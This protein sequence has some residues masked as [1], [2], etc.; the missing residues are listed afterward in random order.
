MQQNKHV[1]VSSSNLKFIILLRS[2]EDELYAD[3]I[4]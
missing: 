3:I 1:Y 4:F 2:L